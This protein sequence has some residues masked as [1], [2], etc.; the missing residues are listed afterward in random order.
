MN[1]LNLP[2]FNVLNLQENE[3][4]YC[5]EVEVDSPP[6][7]CP[8]CGCIDPTLQKYGIKK[9]LFMDIPMHGKSTGIL[10]KRQR[11]KCKECNTTFLEP[12]PH[13]DDKRLATKRLVDYVAK[14]SLR[15]TFTGLAEEVGI[16]EK[17]VRNIFHDYVNHLEA[18]AK[19]ET[20]VCL[21]ID[22][23]HLLKK[24]RCV[25][26]NVKE[27]TL[28]DMLPSR[29]KEPLIRYLMNMPNRKKIQYVAMD[30]WL[31]YRDAIKGTIPGATVVID[32]FHVVKMANQALDAV[33]KATRAS[34]TDK[35]RKAL[36]HDRFILLKRKSDLKPR[37]NLILESWLLNFENLAAAYELKELFY[38]IWD[39]KDRASALAALD[40]WKKS[41]PKDIKP[42]FKDLL[43]ALKNWENEIFNYF[44]YPITN[45]YTEC[46]NGLIRVMNRM[47]RGYS[48]EVIR[49]KMLYTEGTHK[50]IKPRYSKRNFMA[51]MIHPQYAHLNFG[52]DISTLAR[53]LEEGSL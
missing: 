1:I 22:E 18:N 23:I 32:K 14:Q 40:S 21:G 36:M 38:G 34:L 49:A 13:M 11:Y 20:P 53:L 2:R 8:H 17:T 26:T 24:P 45:A 44:D 39:C 37:E 10:V 9:Q 15:K 19:F 41:I 30:M 52:P 42:A 16:D 3:H 28:I 7:F 27:N 35:E 50:E 5:I 25:I 4:D 43:T 47:G 51:D 29:N 33:R 6:Q 31:P 48:F 46:L 12:L